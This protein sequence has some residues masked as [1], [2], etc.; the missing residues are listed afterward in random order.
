VFCKI[1]IVEVS[2]FLWGISRLVGVFFDG[3]AL[4]CANL[5]ENPHSPCATPVYF[6]NYWETSVYSIDVG[7]DELNCGFWKIRG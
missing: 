4:V 2:Q 6:F 3:F 5:N 7:L 1:F